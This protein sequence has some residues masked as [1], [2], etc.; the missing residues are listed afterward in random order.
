MTMQLDQNKVD[1]FL[2]AIDA[3]SKQFEQMRSILKVTDNS[4]DEIVIIAKEHRSFSISDITATSFT[5][6]FEFD[7][8]RYGRTHYRLKSKPDQSFYTRADMTGKW[9]AVGNGHKQPVSGLI[10]GEVYLV[11]SQTTHDNGRTWRDVSPVEE[12]SLLVPNVNNTAPLHE[13]DKHWLSLGY[14]PVFAPA[15]DAADLNKTARQYFEEDEWTLGHRNW[16]NSHIYKTPESDNTEHNKIVL[17]PIDKQPAIRCVIRR[18]HTRGMAVTS[19]Q[20]GDDGLQKRCIVITHEYMTPN[21]HH[22]IIHPDPPDHRSPSGMYKGS[23]HFPFTRQGNQQLSGGGTLFDGAHSIR[24]ALSPDGRFMFWAYIQK[25][26]A[27]KLA[28]KHPGLAFNST[29]RWQ[30]GYQGDWVREDIKIVLNDA[31]KAN[32]ELWLYINGKNIIKETGLELRG[33]DDQWLKGWGFLY[34]HMRMSSPEYEELYL[35]RFKI[36]ACDAEGRTSSIVNE[37]RPG[38]ESAKTW[39]DVFGDS[40]IYSS[41]NNLRV[42][43]A[44]NRLTQTLVPNDQGSTRDESAFRL[45]DGFKQYSVEQVITFDEDWQC[46]R[47]GKVGF[48]LGG[49][50]HTSGGRIDPAGWMSRLMFRPDNTLVLYTY[51]TNR[52]FTNGKPWGDDNPIGVFEPG[53]PV[54]VKMIVGLNDPKQDNGFMA[55]ESDGVQY[56]LKEGVM[57]Q[58]VDQPGDAMRGVYQAFFGGSDKSWSPTSTQRYT[59]TDVVFSWQ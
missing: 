11:N 45:P 48:G 22:K 12:V 6:S 20:F 42:E 10:P 27:R 47:G 40:Y 44:D 19:N 16:R 49:G 7:E 13:M 35:R 14:S 18:G 36:Y 37:Y 4:S 9:G 26:L 34:E 50:T 23:G 55:V 5:A 33:Y 25:G 43:F 30:D 32:G 15:L 39:K 52:E 58:G 24:S 53:E 54:K 8:N 57:W 3:A 2:S 31:G 38:F 46:V 51:Q 56:L 28:G 17:D 59:L 29:L 1:E 21:G 41:P